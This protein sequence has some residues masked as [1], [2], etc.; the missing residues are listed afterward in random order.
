MINK[1][2]LVGNVG[3]DPEVRYIEENLPVARF[4]LATSERMANKG[5]QPQE[6]TEWHNI[7]AWRGLAE[8]AE[9]YIRKGARLYVEGKLT[10][11]SWTDKDKVTHY[12]TEIVA[13]VIQ[14]LDK[15]SD[16]QSTRE[17]KDKDLLAKEVNNLPS[18][19]EG[20]VN[21]IF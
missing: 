21:D 9:K 16:S 7:V 2:I 15:R 5:G 12:S 4:S 13:D 19:T 1:V 3:K 11:R 17:S 6:R 10:Y 18:A 8:V 14:M 20:D